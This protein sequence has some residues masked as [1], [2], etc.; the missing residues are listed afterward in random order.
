MAHSCHWLVYLVLRCSFIEPAIRRMCEISLGA[1][2]T[3][4]CRPELRLFFPPKRNS[5]GS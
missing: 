3:I 5:T 1:V 2:P 4:L